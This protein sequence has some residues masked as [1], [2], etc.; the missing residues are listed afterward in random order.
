MKKYQMDSKMVDYIDSPYKSEQYGVGN[1]FDLEVTLRGLKEEIK[2][3]KV[4]NDKITQ[5]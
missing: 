3:C 2:I 4:D 1:S 5:S